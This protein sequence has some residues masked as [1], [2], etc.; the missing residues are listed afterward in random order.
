M[1]DAMVRVMREASRIRPLIIVFED[2]HWAGSTAV[3]LLR[4]MPSRLEGERV[5]LLCTYRSSGTTRMQD[6]RVALGELGAL[7]RSQRV[8]LEGL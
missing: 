3:A 2:L 7:R 1:F 6:F 8:A 4:F 5:L